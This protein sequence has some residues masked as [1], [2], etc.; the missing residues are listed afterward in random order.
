MCP[1]FLDE[2][3]LVASS[4]DKKI[5]VY[6]DNLGGF[7]RQYTNL[8]FDDIKHNA[9]VY[10][11]HIFDD[12]VRNNYPHLD[13][14]YYGQ[15]PA[16]DKFQAFRVDQS[17]TNTFENFLC[18]FNGHGHVGRQFATALLYKFNLWNNE[19]CSKNFEYSI[20]TLDGNISASMTNDQNARF[21][22]KFFLGHDQKTKTFYQT[23]NGWDYIGKT[24]SHKNHFPILSKKLK[25]SFVKLVTE[26]CCESYY[27]WPTEKILYPIVCDTL[28]LAYAPPKYYEHL[29]K[30]FKIKKYDRIFD[31]S[32]D[33]I[34]NPVERI[35]AIVSQLHS[36]KYLNKFDWHDLWLMEEDTIAYNK[37][38][39]HNGTI[40]QNL[41]KL[42]DIDSIEELCLKRT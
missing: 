4:L 19:Y 5:L 29:E 30:F 41:D 37:E 25:S 28:W 21:Y 16:W 8:L 14:K 31:Y 10:T 6:K 24:G 26:T 42:K 38:I 1:I 20:D 33:D 36:F 15:D 13:F 39:Y 32:F 34:Y 23:A 18:C 12:K 35:F 22:S 27:P 11:Q 3:M 17:L 9:T 2:N 7:D 40:K